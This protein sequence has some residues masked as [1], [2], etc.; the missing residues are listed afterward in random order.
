MCVC[1]LY[2]TNRSHCNFVVSQQ[3]KFQLIII[4]ERVCYSFIYSWI[5]FYIPWLNYC[6]GAKEIFSTS[7]FT[8]TIFSTVQIL[9]SYLKILLWNIIEN[10][11]LLLI[12]SIYSEKILKNRIFTTIFNVVLL[13]F[14][15]NF[16]YFVCRKR[17]NSIKE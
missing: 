13:M 5:L 16:M 12:R 14:F 6:L 2:K 7:I 9:Q 15:C 11:F 1:Q 8:L 10:I 3:I 4:M 17:I